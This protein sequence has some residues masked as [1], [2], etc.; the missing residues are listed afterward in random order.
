MDAPTL[1]REI[2]SRG[3]SIR[4]EGERLKVANDKALTDSLRASIRAHKN[5]LLAL[6]QHGDRFAESS[7]PAAPEPT[8]PK[9]QPAT[10]FR[11]VEQFLL[12]PGRNW[13]APGAAAICSTLQSFERLFAAARGG[14]LPTAPLDVEIS[15]QRWKVESAAAA[16]QLKKEWTGAARRCQSEQRDLT[17]PEKSALDA[18]AEMLE[19]VWGS[20]NGPGE[21]W[22]DLVALN[23]QLD[24]EIKA[25]N[26]R[27]RAAKNCAP[28]EAPS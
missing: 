1:I 13:P 10:P 22:L 24:S 28:S 16:V 19:T 25:V 5:E 9:T 7:A 11:A 15:S 26:Q 4:Y 14:E 18:A 23:R 27:Q 21:M 12:V 2:E 3:A 17:A 8:A 20:Y 6:L